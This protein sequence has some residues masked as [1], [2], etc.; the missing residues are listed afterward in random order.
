MQCYVILDWQ[1]GDGQEESVG[2]QSWK[3]PMLGTRKILERVAGFGD[4]CLE[5]GIPQGRI[6]FSMFFSP[7]NSINIKELQ[8]S[9][10]FGHASRVRRWEIL[11]SCQ[12]LHGNQRTTVTL[13]SSISLCKLGFRGGGGV[14]GEV[15]VGKYCNI[16]KG[17]KISYKF[18]TGLVHSALH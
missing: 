3:A 17:N 7:S 5:P 16:A 1:F 2:T 15:I 12:S 14:E 11:K 6:Y 18:D 13:Q 9:V 8:G 10:G 4:V